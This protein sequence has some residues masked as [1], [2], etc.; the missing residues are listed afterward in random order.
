MTST[1]RGQV[2]IVSGPSGSGKSTLVAG[3]VQKCPLPLV[4]SISATTR[5]PR[6]GET[7][8]QSYH[9]LSQQEF[10][11]RRASG[12]FLECCEVHGRGYWYGTLSSEVAPSLA[13]GKWVVLEID[14]QGAQRVLEYYPQAV[15]IFIHPGSAEELERRLRGRG[16]EQEADIQRRLESAR[17]ESAFADRYR[18]QVTN[19]H[20]DRAVARLC[21]ILQEVKGIS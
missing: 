3:L 8:G 13:A 14:V 19:D 11:R 10:A 18:Y 20:C 7:P 16:T 15:T 1:D 2:V 12:E 4:V 17:R 6:Q 9:F 5:A 21:Q